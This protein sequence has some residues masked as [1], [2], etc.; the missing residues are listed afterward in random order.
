MSRQ[1]QNMKLTILAASG[2][3]GR[4]LTRQA[5]DRGHSVTAIVRDPKRLDVPES[6][7][8]TIVTADLRDPGSLAQAFHDGTTVLSGLGNAN[9]ERPGV[10]TA[11][12]EAVVRGQPERIIWLGG[13]GTGASAAAAGPLTRA[14]LKV[15][16]KAELADKVAADTAVLAAGGTVF[17]AGPLSDGPL[18]GDRRTLSLAEAPRRLF[19]ARVSRATVA[20]SMLDEAESGRHPGKTV[21]PVDR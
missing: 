12:A 3:T 5:L 9:G 8:L 7:H 13:F 10:L 17:H 16:L 20:A 19:P 1:E 15:F 4:E 21:V 18:S 11:G 6:E 14:L 2:A